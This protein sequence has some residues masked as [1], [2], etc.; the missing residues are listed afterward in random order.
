MFSFV[1]KDLLNLL[2]PFSLFMGLMQ[3]LP[4]DP[5]LHTTDRRK[6]RALPGH[7]EE[8]LRL[9]GGS[10]VPCVYLSWESKD[11]GHDG[12]IILYENR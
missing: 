5:L 12:H 3:R 10:T 7:L 8:F 2:S 11:D 1:S 6:C 4:R 9:L